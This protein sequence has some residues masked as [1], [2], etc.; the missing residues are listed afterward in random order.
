MTETL[1]KQA[2]PKCGFSTDAKIECP[3]CGI[4]FAKLEKLLWAKVD[5]PEPKP[6]AEVGILETDP[7]EASPLARFSFNNLSLQFGAFGIAVLFALLL[8]ASSEI[9]YLLIWGVLHPPIHEFGHALGAWMTGHFAFPIFF[10][11]FGLT[12][13]FAARS[14]V[15]ILAVG[16]TEIFLLVQAVFLRSLFGVLLF[17]SLFCLQMYGTFALSPDAQTFI[18]VFGG[19]GAP[20][21]LCGLALIAFFHPAPDRLRW[22]F[23][24]FPLMFW[25]AIIF[26]DAGVQWWNSRI[27]LSAMPWGSVMDGRDSSSGDMQRLL[28]LTHHGAS[29]LAK[30]YWKCFAVT[31]ALVL[32]HT[33]FQFARL[34]AIQTDPLRKKPV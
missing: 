11:G 30:T 6:I 18:I 17:S 9:Q 12:Q 33:C 15:T 13:S 27:N 25:S 10:P 32:A 14:W 29:W 7:D 5:L 4:V 3:H 1:T 20:I 24:R 31:L 21:F 26:V 2:C 19:E 16:G 28:A 23:F 34:V 22:D 8:E